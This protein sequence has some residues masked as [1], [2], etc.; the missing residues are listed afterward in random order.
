MQ[1]ILQNKM[2]GVFYI[3][4]ISYIKKVTNENDVGV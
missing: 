1:D 3:I 2:Q 4:A